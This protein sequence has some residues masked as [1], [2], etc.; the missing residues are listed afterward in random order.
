MTGGLDE[1]GALRDGAGDTKELHFPIP[2]SLQM[3]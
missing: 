2:L 1:S 3:Q